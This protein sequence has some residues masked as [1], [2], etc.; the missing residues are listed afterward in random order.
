M[1]VKKEPDLSEVTFDGT[2][3][4][5]SHHEHLMKLVEPIEVIGSESVLA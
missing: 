2:A 4:V 5:I 1:V 3:S